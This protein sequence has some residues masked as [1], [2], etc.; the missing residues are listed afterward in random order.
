MENSFIGNTMN[1]D[2]SFDD[3]KLTGTF[4]LTYTVTLPDEQLDP[5]VHYHDC[6]ELVFYVSADIQAYIDETHYHLISKDVLIIPPRKM[7]KII[8][9]EHQNYVRYV[10]YFTQD[11]IERFFD[12]DM[13]SKAVHLFKDRPYRKVS[14][15]VPEYMRINNLFKNM[16]EH[17]RA[18]TAHNLALLNAYSALIL[19]ELYLIFDRRPSLP[20]ETGEMSPVD[21]VLKYINAHYSEP[22]AL[23]TLAEEFYLNKS[24]LCRLFHK[25]M[26]ISII[27]YLQH[28]RILEAQQ[29]LLNSSRSIIDI[30]MECGFS[31]IQHFYRVFKKVT[32]LTP[33]EYKNHHSAIKPS[34]K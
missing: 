25:T 15:S 22:I 17:R 32:A 1:M 12:P 14:L 27:N 28:K 7:H 20:P 8:Y 10:L 4:N 18:L 34:Q 30:S 24:Y 19:Q 26:G 16:Y 23:E 5:L 33:A 9:P 21:Q 29:L 2:T 31:N 3:A 6:F 11:H 13:A